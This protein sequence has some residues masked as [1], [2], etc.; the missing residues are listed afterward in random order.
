MGSWKPGE[1]VSRRREASSV[2]DAANWSS[3]L[4]TENLPLDLPE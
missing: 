1:S 4:K 3:K 2:S